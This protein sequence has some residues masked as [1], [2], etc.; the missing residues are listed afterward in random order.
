MG[1][2]IYVKNEGLIKAYDLLKVKISKEE[3]SFDINGENCMNMQFLNKRDIIDRI[4][5]GD[6]IEYKIGNG[7]TVIVR[8]KNF[9]DSL[10]NP[11]NQQNEAVAI[12]GER[13]IY[14]ENFE[15]INLLNDTN[16]EVNE[17]IIKV[18][19]KYG[20]NGSHFYNEIPIN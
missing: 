14:T 17:N 7:K 2:Y 8:V 18:F 13:Y 5:I 12:K 9:I 19:I 11:N 3:D 6:L 10:L 4:Q 1:R 15:K 16:N 20:S